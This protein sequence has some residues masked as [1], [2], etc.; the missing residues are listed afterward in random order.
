MDWLEC[1]ALLLLIAAVSPPV[2]SFVVDL[3]IFEIRVKVVVC[4]K[5][6]KTKGMKGRQAMV[7]PRIGSR[8]VIKETNAACSVYSC[9]S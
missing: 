9:T 6:F 1:S 8:P 4:L 5:C 2:S 7:T 3:R